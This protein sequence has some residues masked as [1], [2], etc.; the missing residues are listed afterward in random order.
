MCRGALKTA[1]FG[2]AEESLQSQKI[3]THLAPFSAAKMPHAS[4]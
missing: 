4:G 1:A 2:D 3:D